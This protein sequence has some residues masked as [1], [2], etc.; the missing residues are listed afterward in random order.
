M[1]IK[2]ERMVFSALSWLGEETWPCKIWSAH[3]TGY[4]QTSAAQ[5]KFTGVCYVGD[6]GDSSELRHPNIWSQE[7]KVIL[8]TVFPF[9]IRISTRVNYLGLGLMTAVLHHLFPVLLTPCL[10]G[11]PMKI[12]SCR[13]KKKTHRGRACFKFMTCV[14][15]LIAHLPL[16]VPR[17]TQ[18]IDPI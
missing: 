7:Q 11:S 12:R 14:Y 5:N 4:F 17:S 8:K 15:V 1:E 3:L 16:V 6:Y 13:W 2:E 9:Q 10:Y 18:H